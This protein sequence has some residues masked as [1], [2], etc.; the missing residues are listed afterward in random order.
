MEPFGIDNAA[1]YQGRR[2]ES[3]RMDVSFLYNPIKSSAEHLQAH[4]YT[5]YAKF[6]Q[7]LGQDHLFIY[8]T[9]HRDTLK[10]KRSW[11]SHLSDEIKDPFAWVE[12]KGLK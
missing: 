12:S 9:L 3:K 5:Q 6:T 11:Y 8:T 10:C 7:G 1:G 2:G 4:V